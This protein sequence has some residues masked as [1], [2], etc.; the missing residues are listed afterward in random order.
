[1]KKKLALLV[2]FSLVLSLV[3]AA[4]V[5]A[6]EAEDNGNEYEYGEVY[7]DEAYNEDAEEADEADEDAE[8]GE[9]ADEIESDESIESVES[10]ELDETDAVEDADVADASEVDEIDEADELDEVNDEDPTEIEDVDGVDDEDYVPVAP[11]TEDPPVTA[12][13]TTLRFVI[14]QN[15]FTRNGVA[16]PA[17]DAAPFIDAATG[18]TMVPVAAVASG[19]GATVA[20]DRESRNVTIVLGDINLVL[21]ADTDLPG[22]A[23][24]PAIVEGRVFVPLAYVADE[25]GAQTRWDRD[26]QAVYVMN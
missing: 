13:Q 23:G 19:L 4:V 16:Q 22:G 25:L 7:Y 5:L 9:E 10:A 8:E 6:D 21:N 18:R 12:D 15:S 1:M 11:I 3:P 17:L 2:A 26:A 24:R 20:W 14:G